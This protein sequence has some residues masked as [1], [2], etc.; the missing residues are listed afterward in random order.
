MARPLILI[1]GPEEKKRIQDLIEFA[2]QHPFSIEAIKKIIDGKAPP[3]GD[4]KGF[5]I[6]IP[7]GFKCVFTIEQQSIGQCKHLSVSVPKKGRWPSI[8][9][10]Q[11][12][13]VEFGFIGNIT[14]L[15]AGTVYKEDESEA[16]NVIQQDDLVPAK[17]TIQ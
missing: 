12:L 10:M 15:V 17:S 9:A 1:I 6:Q 7:F 4:M 13:M 2:R 8:E 16:V 5:T 3:P 11:M 14:N